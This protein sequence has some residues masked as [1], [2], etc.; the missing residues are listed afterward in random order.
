MERLFAIDSSK[1]ISFGED[2]II[3]R[4]DTCFG[5]FLFTSYIIVLDK[6]LYT[7]KMTGFT[8]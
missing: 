4:T 1:N 6:A 2:L 8:P 5:Q 3:S 7:L